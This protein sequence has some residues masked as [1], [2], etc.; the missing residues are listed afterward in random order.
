MKQRMSQIKFKLFPDSRVA[1]DFRM[2]TSLI[3]IL[4]QLIFQELTLSTNSM[5]YQAWKQTPIPMYLKIY[6]FNWTNYKDVIEDSTVKPYFAQLGPYTFRYS[7]RNFE[8]Y[9]HELSSY[10]S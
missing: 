3:Y 4:L 10:K 8:S 7:I 5:S 9:F 1:G 2:I 6:L